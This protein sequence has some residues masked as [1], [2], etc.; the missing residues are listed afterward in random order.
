MTE[1]RYC[2]EALAAV[3]ET[4]EGLHE[5]GAIH[6]R[7]MREFDEC[8]LTPVIA[9]AP[10]EIRAIREREGVSQPVFA[11]YLNV[12]RNLVSD[13]ERGTK[14]PGGPALRLLTLVQRKGLQAIA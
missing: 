10:E 6:K 9:P 2:S 1:K 14:R 13:W 8:C 11:R 5:I 3:H 7:T 12:S 4:M